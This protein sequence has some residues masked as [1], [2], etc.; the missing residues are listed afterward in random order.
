MSKNMRTISSLLRLEHIKIEN[1]KGIDCLEIDFAQPQFE[2]SPDVTVI[3]SQNGLGKT[4]ILECCALLAITITCHHN[5]LIKFDRRHG[6]DLFKKGFS[7]SGNFREEDLQFSRSLT[8]DPKDDNYFKI[9]G[10]SSPKT[11]KKNNT[12]KESLHNFNKN[13]E[14]ILGQTSNQLSMEHFLFFN[15]Y[16]KIQESS[17]ELGMLVHK[18]YEPIFRNRMYETPISLF[19]IEILRSFML[20]NPLLD[21][22]DKQESHEVLKN[23]NDFLNQYAGVKIKKLVPH[24]NNTIDILLEHQKSKDIFS[25]DGL[26]SG[27]KEIISTF[28][29]IWY[30]TRVKSKIILIDEPELHLNRDW[31]QTLVRD[32]VKNAPNNQYILATHSIEVA[33]AVEPYQRILLEKNSIK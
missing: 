27:Q 14:T 23:L 33:E 8:F 29:L 17:P 32:L 4:S 7:I 1:Y 20:D 9:T 31:Q 24:T 30:S 25:F 26:S 18:S 22:I 16:R 15:S 11:I 12:N 2:D 21:Q 19:K 10:K 5:E 6:S 13:I 28:F 3:G